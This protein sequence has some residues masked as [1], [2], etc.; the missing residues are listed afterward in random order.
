[1][2]EIKRLNVYGKS[3]KVCNNIKVTGFNRNGYCTNLDF[4]PGTHIVCAIMTDYFLEFTKSKGNDLIT[5]TKN[6]QGLKSG[7]TWCICIKRWLEAY[8][9][10]K[11]PPIIGDATDIKIL[12]YVPAIILQN[13]VK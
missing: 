1:M 5:P 7:D 2:S 8:Y 6:F 11:A 10:R 4:D 12:E 13:Y 3:L 9:A